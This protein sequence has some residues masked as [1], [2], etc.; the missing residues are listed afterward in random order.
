[1]IVY[2]PHPRWVTDIVRLPLSYALRRAVQ[3][4]LVIGLY[5]TL[6]IALLALAPTVEFPHGATAFGIL[7]GAL[8]LTLAFRV[9]NAYARWWEARQQWGLLVNHSRNL[10]ALVHALWPPEDRAGRARMAGLIGD[11]AVGLSRHLRGELQVTHLESLTDAERQRASGQEH[12]PSYVAHLIFAE[13][14]QRRASGTLDVSRIVELQPHTRAFLDVLGACERIRS[15]P[16]PFAATAVV[17]LFL[18]LFTAS[19]PFGLHTEFGWYAV[20]VSMLTFFIL[21]AMDAIAAE[22]ENPFGIDCNDLPTRYIGEMIRRQVHSLLEV[23]RT[24]EPDQQPAR[25]KPYDKIR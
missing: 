8:S 7:G 19:V 17:R 9:N 20:G 22:L 1:M 16:I 14:E 18:L 10:A 15:T 25:P 5:A 13:V 3:G 11:F 21:A 6:W 2:E 12:V 24:G 23:Q 4:T